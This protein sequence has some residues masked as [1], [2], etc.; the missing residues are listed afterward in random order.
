MLWFGTLIGGIDPFL[1][2]AF[3]SRLLWLAHCQKC[4]DTDFAP[5]GNIRYISVTR[6][7][8]FTMGA[9]GVSN[10]DWSSKLTLYVNVLLMIYS[11][12]AISL[13]ATDTFSA[14]SQR[15][16]NLSFLTEVWKICHFK[17]SEIRIYFFTVNFSLVNDEIHLFLMYSARLPVKFLQILFTEFA[18]SVQNRYISVINYG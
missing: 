18:I 8:C 10:S 7:S 2:S 4:N 14:D 13:L 12:S 15:S 3:R 17:F 9:Y 1:Y 5:F 11:P 6:T 16:Q